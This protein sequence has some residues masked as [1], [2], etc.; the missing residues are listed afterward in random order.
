MSPLSARRVQLLQP[1]CLSPS[2]IVCDSLDPNWALAGRGGTS[3]RCDTFSKL[4][5]IKDQ[6]SREVSFF[7][8]GTS[9]IKSPSGTEPSVLPP[10][11]SLRHRPGLRYHIIWIYSSL[12]RRRRHFV[13]TRRRMLACEHGELLRR[14]QSVSSKS[15][16]HDPYP[17][18]TTSCNDVFFLERKPAR[19]LARKGCTWSHR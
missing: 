12:Y 9:S 16:Y 17:Q 1:F 2:S 8:S 11:H 4:R 13:E 15:S 6:S 19:A 7:Y 10:F 18:P 3:Y 14:C 5:S